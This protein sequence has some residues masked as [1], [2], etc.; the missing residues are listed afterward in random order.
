MNHSGT[1]GSATNFA[2]GNGPFSVAAE[3]FNVDGRQDLVVVNLGNNVSIL[4]NTTAFPVS[5]AF[6]SATELCSGDPTALRGGRGFQW[7]WETGSGGGE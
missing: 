7:G 6:G 4:L 3:D 2:A 5:G 1:F